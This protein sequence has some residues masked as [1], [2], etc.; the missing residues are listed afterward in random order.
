LQVDELCV[1]ARSLSAPQRATATRALARLVRTT[2]CLLSA[3]S[4]AQ[5]AK[6]GESDDFHAAAT[7][8]LARLRPL[9]FPVQLPMLASDLLVDVSLLVRTEAALLVAAL[10]DEDHSSGPKGLKVDPGF[11]SWRAHLAV[12]PTPLSPFRRL[13]VGQAALQSHA[14]SNLRRV[15]WNSFRR[16]EE[17]IDDLQVSHLFDP[18]VDFELCNLVPNGAMNFTHTSFLVA[19]GLG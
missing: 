17:E 13:A 8:V 16:D 2:R 7:K 11:E 5:N 3:I 19:G 10:A 6:L 1:L 18:C 14:A 15:P 12:T 9:R 4:H